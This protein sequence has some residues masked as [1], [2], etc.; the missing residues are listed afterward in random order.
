MINI[1][2]NGKKTEL[3]ST[4]S[5]IEFLRSENLENKM[6]AVAVNMKIILKNEYKTTY[7]KE[8][9]K[10]EGVRPVGGG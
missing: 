8:N 10:V 4:I 7:I 6:V 5:I 1:I 2:L 9:D 3:E